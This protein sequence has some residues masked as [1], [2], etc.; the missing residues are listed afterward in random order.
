MYWEFL[1][2]L[3]KKLE[4]KTVRKDEFHF[5]YAFDTVATVLNFESAGFVEYNEDIVEM[6]NIETMAI[7]E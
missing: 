6:L 7:E 2:S 4:A 1:N 3:R 5:K